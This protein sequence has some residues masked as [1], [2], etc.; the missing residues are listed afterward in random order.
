MLPYKQ[1]NSR[2]RKTKIEGKLLQLE[3]LSSVLM[4]SLEQLE[5]INIR[6]IFKCVDDTLL[7]DD[8]FD[9]R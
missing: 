1:D 6:Y 7:T 4:L 9:C 8:L 3:N 5:T 2:H